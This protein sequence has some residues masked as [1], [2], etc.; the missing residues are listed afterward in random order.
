VIRLLIASLSL[1]VGMLGASIWLTGC[2]GV[3]PAGLSGDGSGGTPTCSAGTDQAC[4]WYVT[5]PGA[6]TEAD[7]AAACKMYM[8][9]PCVDVPICYNSL[10]GGN[11]LVAFQPSIGEYWGWVY[12]GPRAGQIVHALATPTFA[13]ASYACR[14]DGLVIGQPT[15]VPAG[16]W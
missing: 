3:P 10:Q 12:I 4:A 6:R 8:N 9:G 5:K 14:A 2:G 1:A 7:A 11:S 16:L 15:L 13:D